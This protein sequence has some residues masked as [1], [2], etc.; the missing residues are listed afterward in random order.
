[1]AT[2]IT[3]TVA[4]SGGDYTTLAAWDTAQQRDLVAADQIARCELS[5]T[6][7]AAEVSVTITGWAA[8]DATRFIE[9]I[10][11][12]D[13]ARH[14]GKWKS[15]GFRLSGTNFPGLTISESYTFVQGVQA[16]RSTTSSVIQGTFRTNIGALNVQYRECIA[17][18]GT[19]VPAGQALGFYFTPR[20]AAPIRPYAINC[21]AIDESTNGVLLAGFGVEGRVWEGTFVNCGV[22]NARD[23]GFWLHATKNVCINCYSYNATIS[24]YLSGSGGGTGASNNCSSDAS[25]VGS[26]PRINQ[27][28]TFVN[29]GAGDY[30]LDETD[31]AC[32]TFGLDV[33]G[34]FGFNIDID[35]VV[36]NTPW[37]IGSDQFVPSGPSGGGKSILDVTDLTDITGVL[38]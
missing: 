18:Y 5:G 24:D 37:D 9:I 31:A 30:H 17:R 7:V 38:G 27:T 26:S 16:E 1:M 25:A 2:T 29:A 20:D 14:D 22:I 34:T 23:Y 13:G 15:D 4:D 11:L 36:R 32:R 28:F 33:S 8:T 19:T 3:H 12:D 6:F 10:A 35:G 21:L